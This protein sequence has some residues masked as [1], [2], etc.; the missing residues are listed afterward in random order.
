MKEAGLPMGGEAGYMGDAQATTESFDARSVPTTQA[1]RRRPRNGPI[2][3]E[4]PRR[5][6]LQRMVRRRGHKLKMNKTESKRDDV[7]TA[8]LKKRYFE[9]IAK[10]DYPRTPMLT[11]E[12]DNLERAIRE[13]EAKSHATNAA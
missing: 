4:T 10:E 3:T 1:Q 12:A 7:V 8:T 6:S 9:V 13:L 5:R 2:E 11:E